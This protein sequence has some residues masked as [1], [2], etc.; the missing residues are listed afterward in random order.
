MDNGREYCGRVTQHH[1]EIY[2]ELNSI[3]HRKTRIA[4]QDKW[5]CR[6]F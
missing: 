2:L 5:I 4:P 6:M 3:E 1:Y